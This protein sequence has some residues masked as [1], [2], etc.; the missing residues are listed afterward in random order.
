MTEKSRKVPHHN[1]DEYIRVCSS[2]T[3]VII[4]ALSLVLVASI[5]W[6]FTGTLPM[7]LDVTGCMLERGDISSEYTA[8]HD[9]TV[10]ENEMTNGNFAEHTANTQK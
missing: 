3:L 8:Q 2:G 6:G 1:L 9:V 7:T 4:V 10:T 5:V